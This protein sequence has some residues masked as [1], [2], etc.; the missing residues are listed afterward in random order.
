MD[1]V[2]SIFQ[3][4]QSVA[5]V[6]LKL[7]PVITLGLLTNSLTNFQFQESLFQKKKKTTKVKKEAIMLIC[8]LQQNKSLPFLYDFCEWYKVLNNIIDNIYF[9]FAY[10]LI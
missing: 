1:N 5:L 7:P 8:I 9:K 3:F 2:C 6:G 4:I 10:S